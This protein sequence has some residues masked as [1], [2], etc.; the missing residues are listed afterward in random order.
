M[1]K[2][3]FLA[4]LVCM[5]MLFSMALPIS[6]EEG[7]AAKTVTIPASLSYTANIG[8]GQN[9]NMDNYPYRPYVISWT[10]GGAAGQ[11]RVGYIA[12]DLSGVDIAEDEVIAE[13][14]LE[15]TISR[16][17]NVNQSDGPDSF[18]VF[19]TDFSQIYYSGSSIGYPERGTRAAYYTLPGSV[20]EQNSSLAIPI[21][22]DLDLTDYFMEYPSRDGIGL[23]LSNRDDIPLGTHSLVGFYGYNEGTY[24][25]KLVL[26]LGKKA[27]AN[28]SLKAGSKVLGS[29]TMDNLFSGKTYTLTNEQAPK[30]IVEDGKIYLRENANEN[31]TFTPGEGD[32]DIVI[33]YSE[34][35]VVSAS[36]S[37]I[38]VA[39]GG[40]VNPPGEVTVEFSDG[41]KLN[42]KVTWDEEDIAKAEES[43]G[44]HKV[45]GVI[46]DLLN[47]PVELDVNVYEF[48]AQV[49]ILTN[50]GGW[51]WYVEPSGTHIE[52]GDAL[53]TRFQSY[54]AS[55][56]GYTFTK[57][58]TYMGWVEDN[59]SVVVAQYDHDTK[60]YKR[61]VLHDRLEPDDHNNPAVIVLP[62]GRIMAWYSMHTN[63][64]Y[65]YYR[66]SKYPEDISEW[67]EEQYYY[68]QTNTQGDYSTYNATYPTVFP[69]NTGG[70]DGEDRLYV[71]WRGV[72][73]QPTIA[74][75][76]MPDENGKCEVIMGQ[77]QIVNAAYSAN[78]KETGGEGTLRPYTKY[79]YDFERG[80]I[81]VT[82]TYTHPDNAAQ[83]PI[84][85]IYIN[86]ADQGIYT[87]KGRRIQDI[88]VE[89]DHRYYKSYRNEKWGVTVQDWV[90][91]YPELVVFDP[92]GE[93]RRGWTWDIKV[94]EKGEPCI[95]YADITDQP[96][97]PG[98]TLPESFPDTSE[99]RCH[100]YYWYARWDSETE[101]WVNTFLT[102]GGKWFHENATQ[103]RCYSGGLTLD[104]NAPNANVVF[105]AKPTIGKY[106]NIFEIYR[107]ES[108][109]NGATWPVELQT[110]ITQNSK[111]NNARPNAI[112]NYK[113]DENGNHQGPRILWIS[114]EYR[115][116][117]NYEY[118]T[119]VMTDFPGIEPEDDPE[120]KADAFLTVNGGEPEKLSKDLEGEEFLAKFVLSNISIGDGKAMVGIAHYDKDNKLKSI[121]TETVTVPGRSVPQY[122]VPGAPKGRE[123]GTYSTL[124]SEEIKVYVDYTPENIEEGDR[125]SLLAYSMGKYKLLPIISIPYEI[126]TEGPRFVDRDQI[127]YDGDEILKLGDGEAYN[128]WIASLNKASTSYD[129]CF[130]ENNYVAVTRA[131][132]GNTAIHLYHATSSTTSGDPNGAGG[133][134]VS[135]HL[136]LDKLTDED[137]NYVDYEIRFNMRLINELSWSNNNYLGFALSNGIT[138]GNIEINSEDAHPVAYQFRFRNSWSGT[139]GRRGWI[140]AFTSP[141]FGDETGA[142]TVIEWVDGVV[143]NNSDRLFEGSLWD[144]RIIVRPNDRKIETYVFDGYRTGYFVQDYNGELINWN[145]NP[146]DTIT[147][148]SGI[149]NWC[150]IYIDD[151]RVSKYEE[152]PVKTYPEGE[153]LTIV[154]ASAK[155]GEVSYAYDAN[156]NTM[157]SATYLKSDPTPEIIFDLGKRYTIS[158][159]GIQPG[160]YLTYRYDIYV[161]KD[162]KNW[163]RVF[164]G[165]SNSSR[166]MEYRSGQHK[167]ARYVKVRTNGNTS[168]QVF[169]L[170]EIEIWGY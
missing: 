108:P 89:N 140:S 119:G 37:P 124:G 144:I 6:A 114:G 154:K 147:F 11:Y 72:H 38:R 17:Q 103:E 125:I 22:I 104:H 58:R 138:R 55:N 100:H 5:L 145:L 1:F 134:F 131:P 105:L 170:A 49:S 24:A 41:Q 56:K 160:G 129:P 74:Q 136:P 23:Y 127:Y 12:F 8:T 132:F 91:E 44:D 75:F 109:D 163:E 21:T 63:E 48:E 36:A 29:F 164:R 46:A 2:K 53:A 4:V 152:K 98:E 168:T 88:P 40:K 73:W 67:H 150:E 68:C 99:D 79:D 101:E 165:N 34:V 7:G 87:A 27:K 50:N 19:T 123:E 65:M 47:T 9:A 94:N 76:T 102:Y 128:G 156:I 143:G 13:A 32:N 64:P 111:I 159:I 157:W 81:H 93:A 151:F 52:P 18:S 69:V 77:T 161:S 42:F 31:A 57:D 117:M 20:P 106:G 30:Y 162:G 107:W 97:G 118:K 16:T 84:Y 146:I 141:Y 3:R 35:T 96:P 59:G 113:M 142:K 90:D 166:N 149:S 39:F 43:I 115:Y 155:Q 121:K 15:L 92:K 80:K 126:T 26:T 70:K 133:I 71:F 120:M 14:K 110:P 148:H 167:E 28:I 169:D 54:Y 66:V 78:G 51:N 95:V 60:E 116:W 83:N 153:K 62:D 122:P 45:S 139:N 33:N 10:L 137:G 85:Y 61:V 130:G 158:K 25:P 135:R 112:Y 86:I 82:F